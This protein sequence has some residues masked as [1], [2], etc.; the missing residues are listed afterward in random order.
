MIKLA[1]SRSQ[2]VTIVLFV[3][4]CVLTLVFLWVSFGGPVPFG[5]QGYRFN[6]EFA[7]AVEL[8]TQADVRI[9]GVNVGKVVSTALDRQSGL[10]RA[11]LEIDPQ[12]APRPVNTRATL[13]TKSLLGET[14]VDLTPGTATTPPLPDG[15]TLPAAQVAPTVQLDQILSTFDP[16][17]R[18]AF[19]IWMQQGGIALTGRGESLNQAIAWL[20]PFATNVDSVLTV[21]NREAEATTALISG[22]GQTFSA[23]AQSPAALQGLIRNSNTVF[24]ATAAQDAAL[25]AT[26]RAFPAFLV[27]TRLTVDRATRFATQTQPLINQLLPA[28]RELSPA[29]VALGPVVPQ[30]NDIFTYLGPLTEAATPGIP[31]LERFLDQTVPL[32]ARL[33]PYLGGVVPV[34]NYINDYRKEVA[35]FFA[36]STAATNAHTPEATGPIAH[37]VRAPQPVSPQSVAAYAARLDSSRAGSYL[38]PGGYNQL[39]HGLPVFGSW[40]CTTNPAPAIGSTVSADNATTLQ[41]FYYT[42]NPAGPPCLAQPPLGQLTTGQPYAFPHLTAIP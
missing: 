27:S 35:G 41:T 40:L 37:Y 36:S 38:E 10:T 6:V 17:T 22:A 31:A 12:Y 18:R 14:Y 33:T 32:F 2:M 28:A 25:A 16:V 21:L 7:Q 34:L 26:F 42:Q 5:A 8:G 4:S 11:T 39:T 23:L 3:V 29:L 24:A 30:L 15:A 19:Q 13:R 1:P 9:S 20:D